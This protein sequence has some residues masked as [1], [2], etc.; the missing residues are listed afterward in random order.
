MRYEEDEFYHDTSTFSHPRII[1]TTL[2]YPDKNPKHTRNSTH[3]FPRGGNHVTVVKYN[4]GKNV[5]RKQEFESAALPPSHKLD[6]FPSVR[7]A[8]CAP[9]EM[10]DQSRAD[11]SGFAVGNP[12]ERPKAGTYGVDTRRNVH[13]I[14]FPIYPRENPEENARESSPVESRR[15]ETKRIEVH[16]T[17]SVHFRLP[18]ITPSIPVTRPQELKQTFIDF[19]FTSFIHFRSRSQFS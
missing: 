7:F 13:E 15:D 6:F 2:R 10:P 19:H 1:R 4:E 5:T 18:P 17:S 16:C 9:V 12:R 14:L 11:L 8:S 3:L